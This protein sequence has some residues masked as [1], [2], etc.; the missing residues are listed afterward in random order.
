MATKKRDNSVF[1]LVILL[2]GMFIGTAIGIAIEASISPAPDQ[3]FTN[4]SA[5]NISDCIPITFNQTLV[6]STLQNYK[7]VNLIAIQCPAV[8]QIVYYANLYLN[9][10]VVNK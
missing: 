10:S 5:V 9:Q 7:E 8:Q 1:A 4:E 2:I 6:N 3:I